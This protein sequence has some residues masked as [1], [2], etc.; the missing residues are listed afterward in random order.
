M[1]GHFVVGVLNRDGEKE[2]K[3][4]GWFSEKDRS[5]RG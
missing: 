4:P 5:R 1:N 3:K 2:C